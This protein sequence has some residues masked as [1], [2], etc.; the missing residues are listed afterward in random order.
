MNENESETDGG[1]DVREVTG[2]RE[3]KR[4]R[5]TDEALAD[6]LRRNG[7]WVS[8]AARAC[9]LT[10]SAVSMRIARNPKLKAAVADIREE[11]LDD[12]EDALMARI[13]AGDERAIEFFLKCRGRERGWVEKVEFEGAVRPGASK[14]FTRAELLDMAGAIEAPK[15]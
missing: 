10:P 12:V 4:R 1:A 7:G 13:R 9:G 11:A 15:P 3:R 5:V 2:Q 14:K 8:K 6:A